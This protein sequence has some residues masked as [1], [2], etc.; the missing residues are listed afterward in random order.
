MLSTFMKLK[1]LIKLQINCVLL[2]R[3]GA[4]SQHELS[5]VETVE[6]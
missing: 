1:L 2:A 4:D 3:R 5:F 6:G